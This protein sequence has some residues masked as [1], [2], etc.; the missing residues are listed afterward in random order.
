M[1]RGRRAGEDR[2]P[3]GGDLAA[4]TPSGLLEMTVRETL[5]AELEV[6]SADVTHHT[7]LLARS[8]YDLYETRGFQRA[9]VPGNAPARSWPTPPR[10]GSIAPKRARRTPL[11]GFVVEVLIRTG[12]HGRCAGQRHAPGPTVAGAQTEQRLKVTYLTE[13]TAPE[14]ALPIK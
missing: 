4:T 14:R 9:R 13:H 8:A 12:R 3:L 1:Q 2:L 11:T 7:M 5:D 10:R 6:L